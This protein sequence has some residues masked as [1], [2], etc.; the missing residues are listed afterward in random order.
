M[1]ERPDFLNLNDHAAD[2]SFRRKCLRLLHD[3][4]EKHAVSFGKKVIS[5]DVTVGGF[6]V[7][8]IHGSLCVYHDDIIWT[9][10]YSPWAVE[11]HEAAEYEAMLDQLMV[12]ERL[13]DV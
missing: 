8:Y 12:L 2:C 11:D 3:R 6:Y 13:A 1:S 9:D 7:V 5:W 10:A 4:G